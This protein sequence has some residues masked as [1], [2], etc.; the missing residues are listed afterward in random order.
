M[1]KI[2]AFMLCCMMMVGALSAFAE[3]GIT[4]RIDCNHTYGTTI[5]PG[6]KGVDAGTCRLKDLYK[7]VCDECGTVVDSWAEYYPQHEGPIQEVN[8]V[9]ICKACGDPA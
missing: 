7:E 2:I 5:V 8:G 4:P 9:D 1:K 6:K 3:N